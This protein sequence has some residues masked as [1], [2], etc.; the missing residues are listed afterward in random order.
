ML[1]WWL[2]G[3]ALATGATLFAVNRAGQGSEEPAQ[4][5]FDFAAFSGVAG[6]VG[7][8][9]DRPAGV[10]NAQR[11]P[12]NGNLQFSP[13]VRAS[14]ADGTSIDWTAG[15]AGS[16]GGLLADILAGLGNMFTGGSTFVPAT[17]TP[18]VINPNVGP[19]IPGY[20]DPP[21]ATY[22]PGKRPG[23]VYGDGTKGGNYFVPVVP[24]NDPYL[25]APWQPDPVTGRPPITPPP[26]VNLQPGDFNGVW[27]GP[28]SFPE[29]RQDT[30]VPF[31]E[32]PVYVPPEF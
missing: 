30:Y 21:E 29:Y 27:S 32:P 12:F 28:V 2:I 31:L 19:Y 8:S 24:W 14:R 17:S 22:D 15:T 26:G 3:G 23:D 20:N 1:N 11:A 5:A 18:P 25:P 13:R 16:G 4:S 9:R 7:P 6:A 10:A